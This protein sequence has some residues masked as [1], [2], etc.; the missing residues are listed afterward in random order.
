MATLKDIAKIANVNVSTV[1]KALRDSSDLNVQTVALI[2]SISE[3]LGYSQKS[4]DKN[5]PSSVVGVICPEIISAYYTSMLDSLRRHLLKQGFRMMLTISGFSEEEEI[6]CVKQLIKGKVCSI[7][8]F[9]EQN[10]HSSK[11]KEIMEKNNVVLLIVSMGEENHFCDSICVDDWQSAL[12]AVNHLIDLGHTRIGYIGDNLSLLRRNAY[13]KVLM[14][15][16]LPV[17][18]SL[19]F[20]AELRFEKCG[21][22]GMQKMLMQDPLPTAIFSAYDNIAIGAM[23]AAFEAGL[24]IPDDIS[25]VSI[26]DIQVSSFLNVRLTTVTEPTRDLGELA[27]DLIVKKIRDKRKIIQNIKLKPTLNVRETTAP[28]KQSFT[29]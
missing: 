24:A 29:S 16:G 2:R 17:E 1:S 4:A 7:I 15:N 27:A 14:I 12:L 9:S 6:S 28:P 19:I 21:Y 25:I 20:Q 8:C 26:D 5:E 22:A 10:E 13:E 23:R 3:Q 11:F 18:D